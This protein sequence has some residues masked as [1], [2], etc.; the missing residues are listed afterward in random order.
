MKLVKKIGAILGGL[1]IIAGLGALFMW[2]VIAFSSARGGREQI[3]KN[4][5]TLQKTS[6][7]EKELQSVACA[8]AGRLKAL[9]EVV[10]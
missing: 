1:I 9:K 10:K 7:R 8:L 4:D 6:K 2:R 5:E 3:E